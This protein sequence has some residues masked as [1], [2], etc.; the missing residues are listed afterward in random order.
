VYS[1]VDSDFLNCVTCDRPPREPGGILL[2]PP[3]AH[4]FARQQLICVQCYPLLVG[5]VISILESNERLKDRVILQ[6][7]QQA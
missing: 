6:K 4:G 3:T 5:A 2:G 1:L 7:G